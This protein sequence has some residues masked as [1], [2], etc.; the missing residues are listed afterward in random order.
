[1]AQVRDATLADAERLAQIHVDSWRAAYRGHFPEEFLTGLSVERRVQGWRRFL[2][3]ADPGQAALVIE[4]DGV[5]AGFSRLGPSPDIGE[6]YAIYLDPEYWGRGLGRVL[7]EASEE[8][9]RRMGFEEAVLWVLEGNERARGLYEAAGW[10][11][12]GAFKIEP[13]GLVDANEVRYR[14]RL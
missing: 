7:L 13:I 8:R 6:V 11:P 4:D 5:V 10:R 3:E 9:L 2:S 12:D 1:M 14:V